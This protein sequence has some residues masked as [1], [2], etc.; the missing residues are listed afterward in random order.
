MSLILALKRRMPTM[1]PYLG[2]LFSRLLR[3]CL[4]VASC[5]FSTSH[6]SIANPYFSL[7]KHKISVDELPYYIHDVIV[8]QQE[9]HLWGYGVHAAHLL[10]EDSISTELRAFLAPFFPVSEQKQG[11]IVR[12]NKVLIMP[13]WG[14]NT[15]ELSLTFISKNQNEYKHLFSTSSLKSWAMS[16]PCDENVCFQSM[17][18]SA[19]EACFQT[20]SK[21]IKEDKLHKFP[22]LPDHLNKVQI[23]RESWPVLRPK[24][25]TIGWYRTY[26]DFLQQRID[27]NVRLRA[28]RSFLFNR[29][30]VRGALAFRMS[31]WG[32]TDGTFDYFREADILHKLVFDPVDSIFSYEN[33]F[34][35]YSID[36]LTGR[37]F[38]KRETFCDLIIETEPSLGTDSICIVYY[39]KTIACLKNSEY[40]RIAVQP[41]HGIAQFTFSTSEHS[42]TMYYNPLWSNLINLKTTKGHVI[43]KSW[44]HDSPKQLSRYLIK[45][46]F[47]T[48]L[49]HPVWID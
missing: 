35:T 29:L 25:G 14:R 23:N 46:R 9:K 43:Y 12:V 26:D 45:K 8:A 18:V 15:A 22:V 44:I 32:Y 17:L 48:P 3:S 33:E 16:R 5:V 27:T 7:S 6:L 42:R 2:A 24:E 20:F 36:A 13:W 40:V 19:I 47:V 21:Q 34:L 38:V 39:G 41:E 1:P 31:H 30:T 10:N 37:D 4:F 49:H 28:K 11:L